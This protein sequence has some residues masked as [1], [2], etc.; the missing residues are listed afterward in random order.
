MP[1]IS[2]TTS[3]GIF[4]FSAGIFGRVRNIRQSQEYSAESGIFGTERNI[5]QSQEYS[6]EKGIFG[7][8]RNIRQSATRNIHPSVARVL[9]VK[10]ACRN[11]H[12]SVARVIF[13][14]VACRNIHQSVTILKFV[15]PCVA[16][17][18]SRLIDPGDVHSLSPATHHHYMQSGNLLCWD[19]GKL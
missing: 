15:R 4:D 11:I 12:P 18:S 19:K 17:R 5:R 3:S 7:R 8:V 10:V 16:E 9:F 2:A 14:K 6:A 13:L 1:G